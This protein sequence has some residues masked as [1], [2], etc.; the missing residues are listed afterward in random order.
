MSERLRKLQKDRFPVRFIAS[1]TNARG[2]L[3]AA[4]GVIAS[5]ALTGC[6][7]SEG[8]VATTAPATPLTT[9]TNYATVTLIRPAPAAS[10][11][12]TGAVLTAMGLPP[13]SAAGAA[14]AEVVVRTDDGR[15]LS[16]M[17]PDAPGIVPGARV[18]VVADPSLRVVRPGFTA[19]TS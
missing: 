18:V 7:A 14:E 19:P 13:T 17:Q 2:G 8:R 15:T 6:A 9:G 1:I 5:L 4:L 3:G 12:G 16:V 11:Q 10:P